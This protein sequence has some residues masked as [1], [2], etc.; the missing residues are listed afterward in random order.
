MSGLIAPE[1]YDRLVTEMIN[2]ERPHLFAVLREYGERVDTEIA[3]W[4]MA[5]PDHVEVVLGGG[6][7]LQ[8]SSP[9]R[10]KKF[11]RLGHDCEVRIVWLDQPRQAS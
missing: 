11:V 6:A 5:W 10:V 3:G 9:E 4:G 8:S 2:D 1:Q 7:R